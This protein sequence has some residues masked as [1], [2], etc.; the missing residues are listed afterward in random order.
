M[1]HKIVKTLRPMAQ[2]I[3]I[4]MLPP[5]WMELIKA[6]KK[7]PL[8]YS[9]KGSFMPTTHKTVLRRMKKEYRQLNHL[10][11][12]LLRKNSRISIVNN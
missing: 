9:A 3:Y 1:N 8:P 11:R 4:S 6:G 2:E 10:Q 7:I 12:G 5:N